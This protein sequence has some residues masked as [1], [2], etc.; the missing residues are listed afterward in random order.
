MTSFNRKAVILI[1]VILVPLV[2]QDHIFSFHYIDL[3]P[4]WRKQIPKSVILTPETEV[5]FERS[6]G[7]FGLDQTRFPPFN[8]LKDIVVPPSLASNS[9]AHL[10][11]VFSF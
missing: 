7:D 9:L 5:G 6:L 11:P 2:C 4:S 1:L 10:L 3:F 8:A